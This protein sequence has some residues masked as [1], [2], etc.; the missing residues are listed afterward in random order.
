MFLSSEPSAHRLPCVRRAAHELWWHL[1]RPRGLPP[2]HQ[3]TSQQAMLYAFGAVVLASQEPPQKPNQTLPFPARE[4]NAL[5]QQRRCLFFFLSFHSHVLLI[6][7]ADN[8]AWSSGSCKPSQPCWFLQSET[9]ILQ[10]RTRS[11]V[12]QQQPNWIQPVWLGWLQQPNKHPLTAEGT[13]LGQGWM[14][15]KIL[16]CSYRNGW[17]QLRNLRV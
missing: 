12:L 10:R 4:E 14:L 6:Q 15:L 13:A 8:K 2:G 11:S 1:A 9:D 3:E 17:L 5:P 16:P 7:H